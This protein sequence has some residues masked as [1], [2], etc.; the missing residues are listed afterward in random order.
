MV[1]LIYHRR[2]FR[3]TDLQ[4]LFNSNCM[5][6][7]T[8]KKGLKGKIASG[9]SKQWPGLG[10]SS[11]IKVWVLNPGVDS[12][13][14]HIQYYYDFSQSIAEYTRVFADLGVSWVWQRVTMA[15]Y[16]SVISGIR[17]ASG[18]KVPVVL[19]LCDGDEV[20]GAP[21]LSVIDCLERHRL[22]YT[23]ADRQF[24][25]ITTSKIPMKEA[26]ARSGVSTPG[27]EVVLENRLEGLV[28]RINA[29]IL[30]KPAV[31]GGSMGVSVKNVVYNSEELKQRFF[32]MK[33]GYRGWDLLADGL[34]A[35]CF[36][37]GREFTSFVLGSDSPKVFPAVERVFHKSLRDEEK[38]LSFDRLWEIYEEESAMP[39][40]GNFYDY[41]LAPADL[42]EDIARL[43]LE[44]YRSVGGK[45]YGR[46][47]LRMDERSGQLYVLE[48]NAQCG[49]SED[50][51]FTSIGA[52]LRFAGEDFADLV[53]DI[54]IDAFVRRGILVA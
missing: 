15:D 39:E 45:G 50:E 16:E 49:I 3:N 10:D 14:P 48:V 6:A 36:V 43:S 51:N 21:G 2:R 8:G 9:L 53:K 35:E 47:D 5:I 23:G 7:R 54:L 20:N 44:A 52:I 41:A 28:G 12:D 33:G 25:D 18:R 24:Y 11:R 42:Q 32:E 17:K 27:W 31:S 4:D 29:P 30:L 19:N 37:V 26:F 38:F 46:L 40:E 13:D 22:V 34:I 1:L